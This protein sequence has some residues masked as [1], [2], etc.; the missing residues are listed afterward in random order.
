VT[1][2]RAGL[3]RGI[4]SQIEFLR[5]HA[6][7]RP[8]RTEARLASWR[9]LSLRRRPVTVNLPDLGFRLELPAEWRG[10]SK[11]AYVF[12]EDA[13]PELRHLGLV[14]PPGGTAIDVGAHYGDY[15]LAL[16]K[17]VGPKGRV[18]AVEPMRHALDVLKRNVA[19][20][21]ASNVDVEPVG[22]GRNPGRATL[23]L[24][25]DPSRATLG[26][27]EQEGASES[28]AITTLDHIVQRSG[29][30]RVDF[31]K[32]DI[33]GCEY[34]ALKGGRS[35][36]ERHQPVIQFEHQP[37][38]AKRLGHSGTAVWALLTELGFGFAA[39]NDI[40]RLHR[41]DGPGR[42]GPNYFAI[43][44]RRSHLITDPP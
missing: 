22:V 39:M 8:G 15:T 13:E 36:I 9:L 5:H 7:Y 29:L 2:P 12:R 24:H 25:A 1:G 3:A 19:L 17:V 33:E 23:H 38:A 26:E 42:W 18:V 35:A 44:D 4:P 28:I 37:G 30:Q 34:D 27:L 6:G 11:L 32:L 10:M 43:P 41:V 14:V 20:N 40:G 31:V 16:S 21:R